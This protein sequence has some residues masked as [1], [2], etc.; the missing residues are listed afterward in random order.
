M[1]FPL[2]VTVVEFPMD[3]SYIMLWL[4]VAYPL[5]IVR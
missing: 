4:H 2:M 5:G 3:I 1:D